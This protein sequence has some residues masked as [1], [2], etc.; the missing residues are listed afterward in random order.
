MAYLVHKYKSYYAVFSLKG[1]KKWIKIGNVNKPQAKKILKQLELDNT[2]KSL[3]KPKKD[4]YLY[5]FIDRYLQYAKT[6]KAPK[7]VKEE[8]RAFNLF[9]KFAGNIKLK[10]ISMELIEEYKKAR[11]AKGLKPNS[12][13]RELA[14]IRILL[15]KAK[16]FG[17]LESV[18]KFKLLKIPKQPPK[19]LTHDE[20]ISLIS[21]ASSWLRPMLIVLINT[22]IRTNELLNLRFEDI[23]LDKRCLYIKSG[24]T[25]NYRFI[26][27]NDELLKTLTWLQDYYPLPN[28]TKVLKRHYQQREYLF[29][30]YDGSAINS[31]SKSFKNACTKA[32]VKATPH[33]LRH[34]FAS[35]LLAQGL[36]LVS[37]K[38]ILGHSQ[39]STTLIYTHTLDKHKKDYLNKLSLFCDY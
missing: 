25:N 28:G 15:N 4:G 16:D 34:T 7:T 18:P 19:Y 39:I 22:G 26:P 9:K 8:I 17:Y 32:G 3:F 31:I 12:T 35:Q 6:N 10:D 5:S 24:K 14:Y 27:I 23:D 2:L 38:E 33:M 36:D 13:N 1:K 37:I 29:C 30:K 21:N 20:I 11:V